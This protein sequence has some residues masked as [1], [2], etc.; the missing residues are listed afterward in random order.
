MKDVTGLFGVIM[1]NFSIEGGAIDAAAAS[2][3]I[4]LIEQSAERKIPVIMF[5]Q[6]A[7]M[8]VDAGPESVS[9]MTAIN[10]TIARYFEKTKGLSH[11]RIFSVPFGIC[12]GGT[13]ASF[14]QA[15]GVVVVPIGLSE[16]PFAGRIVTL[17]LL[18]LESTIADL[19][20]GK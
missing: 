20:V 8:F 14:A 12:T 5:L 13:A 9:S 7:G 3:I 6:S 15:P 18:P 4:R 17:E 11:C 19:Q 1:L 2:N 16:I 10:F